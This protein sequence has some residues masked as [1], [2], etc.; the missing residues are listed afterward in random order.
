MLTIGLA[1]NSATVQYGRSDGSPPYLLAVAH[2][3]VEDGT[4]M[5]FL[6]GNTPTSVSRRFCLPVGE[7]EKIASEFVT[8]VGKPAVTTW[9]A[10]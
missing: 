8:Q 10:I 5:E 3:A 9:E 4:F 6:A 2:E 1:A 7:V